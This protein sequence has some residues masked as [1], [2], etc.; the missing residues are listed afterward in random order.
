M[1]FDEI[2]SIKSGKKD[3]KKFGI[4]VGVV[5]AAI[6][7]L[8]LIKKND[9]FIIVYAAAGLC[10]LL[11]LAAPNL[12]KPI[13]KVWMTLAILL[14]WLMTRVILTAAYY[15]IFTL[16]GVISRLFGKEYLDKKWNKDAEK[17]YWIKKTRAPGKERYE[18]QF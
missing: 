18:N 11:G 13:Q 1:I 5:L 9:A 4:T 7:S 6:A 2:K 14:G 17:S 15:V 16:I 10:I 8:L 12:L 3:L